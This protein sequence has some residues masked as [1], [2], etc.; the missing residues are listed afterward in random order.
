M[1]D[2]QDKIFNTC[3]L[4]DLMHRKGL[5]MRFAWILLAKTKLQFSREIVMADILVRVVRKIVNEEIKIKLIDNFSQPNNVMTQQLAALN[6]N[7]ASQNFQAYSHNDL[8]KESLVT[9]LNALLKNKFAKYKHIFEEV[10]VGLFLSRL[11]VLSFSHLLELRTPELHFL[12]SRD[13]LN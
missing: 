3:S 9:I 2:H 1:L 7:K 12:E 4:K 10:L 13:I 6:K 11:K 5:N 8:F